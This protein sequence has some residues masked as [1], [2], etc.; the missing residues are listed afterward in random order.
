M[1][2]LTTFNYIKLHTTA[3]TGHT[4]LVLLVCVCVCV[5]VCECVCVCDVITRGW[6]LRDTCYLA[7]HEEFAH[8]L[9]SGGLPS[10]TEFGRSV[11]CFF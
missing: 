3:T 8:H 7:S 4:P 1:T 9:L 5:C 10:P 6:R 2:A 11:L